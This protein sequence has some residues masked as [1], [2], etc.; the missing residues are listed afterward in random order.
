MLG[1][2]NDE[3]EIVFVQEDKWI[4]ETQ[5]RTDYGFFGSVFS[6]GCDVRN[7]VGKSSRWEPMDHDVESERNLGPQRKKTVV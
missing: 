6:I 2:Q 3:A 7:L 4:L 5:R 1:G